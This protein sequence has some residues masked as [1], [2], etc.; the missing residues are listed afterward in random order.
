MLSS[1]RRPTAPRFEAVPHDAA[2]SSC[3][4]DQRN[5]YIILAQRPRGGETGPAGTDDYY[6][7]ARRRLQCV[8]DGCEPSEDETS[9]HCVMRSATQ[10]CNA[11]IEFVKQATNE[12][13]HERLLALRNTGKHTVYASYF[14][15]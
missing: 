5:V 14:E 10:L 7:L 4:I 3:G 6:F 1:F 13:D 2:R 15:G 11:V 9:L 12:C 8:D